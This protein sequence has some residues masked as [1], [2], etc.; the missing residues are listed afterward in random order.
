[1]T[2]KSGRCVDQFWFMPWQRKQR[3]VDQFR[4]N[5]EHTSRRNFKLVT[6]G[7]G[8]NDPSEKSKIW[9]PT[10]QPETR[11]LRIE[12]RQPER[13]N[14]MIMKFRSLR[15]RDFFK[16]RQKCRNI[17]TATAWPVGCLVTIL[18]FTNWNGH[19]HLL[20]APW[21]W[22]N[23]SP[24]KVQASEE[25]HA[26]QMGWVQDTVLPVLRH[27]HLRHWSIKRKAS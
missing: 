6:R 25:G 13:A 11:I 8:G 17:F 19:K 4:N 2:N 26:N 27:F 10:L 9:F 22:Y 5:S 21:P 20:Y 1:M 23:W 15:G 3:C 18:P 16:Q 12:D 7:G 24:Q 14:L